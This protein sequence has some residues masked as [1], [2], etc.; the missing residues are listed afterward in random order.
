MRKGAVA[1]NEPVFVIPATHAGEVVG[2]KIACSS[3]ADHAMS[4][5]MP[6]PLEPPRYQARRTRA[7][8]VARLDDRQIEL[9]QLLRLEIASCAEAA[10]LLV[11]LFVAVPLKH[12]GGWDV[13]VRVMGPVHGLTFLAYNWIAVQTVA[14]SDWRRAEIVRLFALAIVPFGGFVNLRFLSRKIKALRQAAPR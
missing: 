12:L 4:T 2:T 9:T 10:T 3:A 14:G 1:V 5:H 8:A 6:A 7:A 13:G 11:L